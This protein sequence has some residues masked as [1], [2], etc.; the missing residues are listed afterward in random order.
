MCMHACM[1]VYAEVMRYINAIRSKFRFLP[2]AFSQMTEI[3]DILKTC[4]CIDAS[5]H[6]CIHTQVHTHT[7]KGKESI[8]D[9]IGNFRVL[10]YMH[11]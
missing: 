1:Q 4:A 3:V 5:M 2:F 8:A 11:K 9:L 7:R 6:A 10:M